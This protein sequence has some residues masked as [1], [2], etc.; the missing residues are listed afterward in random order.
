MGVE[1]VF[2]LVFWPEDPEMPESIL[3]LHLVQFPQWKDQEQ[4][5]F[6]AGKEKISQDGVVRLSRPR[7]S[8]SCPTF[9]K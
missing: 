9:C 2:I 7:D 8:C 1:L 4:G 3:E 5:K 6:C